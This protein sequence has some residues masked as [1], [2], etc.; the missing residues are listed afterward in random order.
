MAKKGEYRQNTSEVNRI[1]NNRRAGTLRPLPVGNTRYLDYIM[2]Y[3]EQASGCPDLGYNMLL[4]SSSFSYY[5]ANR[6]NKMDDW[7]A[8]DY[9]DDMVNNLGMLEAIV[10]CDVDEYIS[11][12][13]NNGNTF[14]EIKDPEYLNEIVEGKPVRG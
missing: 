5:R 13:I 6:I 10:E 3:M 7:E 8:L 2:N 11:E 12:E 9:I 1:N 14:Y 4:N